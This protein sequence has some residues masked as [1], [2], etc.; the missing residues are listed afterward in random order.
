MQGE[1][2][3]IHLK[4][5][6]PIPKVGGGEVM[7][8]KLEMGRLKLKHLRLLP[9]D[10]AANEGQVEPSALLPL[11][12]GVMEIPEESAGEI[13]FEDVVALSEALSSFLAVSPL[14]G[15]T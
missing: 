1:K 9:K 14:I 13:D 8:D 7:V 6:I 10:F 15:K 4:Y 11:I 3:T 5:S 12:A 2:K